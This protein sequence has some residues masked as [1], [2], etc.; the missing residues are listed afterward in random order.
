[1]L[2]QAQ[3]PKLFGF[4]AENAKVRKDILPQETEVIW[5]KPEAEVIFQTSS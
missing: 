4:T 3:Q 2:R 1:M 5:L